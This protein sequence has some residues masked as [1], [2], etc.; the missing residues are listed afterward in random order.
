MSF[1]VK[2]LINIAALFLVINIV[3]GVSADNWTTIAAAALVIG[4]LNA[5]LRPLMILLTLPLTILTFG[6]FTLIIN[7]FVFY[8]AANFI[9]GFVV[10]SFWNAFWASIV[11]SI[12]SFALNTL[13]FPSGSARVNSRRYRSASHHKTEHKKYDD[14]IDVEGKVED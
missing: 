14:V 1:L 2:W 9:K 7:A 13:F 10:T 11:F 5:F 3:A 12:L 4:L 6:L 8:L